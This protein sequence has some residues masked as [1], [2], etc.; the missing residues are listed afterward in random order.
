[1]VLRDHARRRCGWRRGGWKAR[2]WE[3]NPGCSLG[4]GCGPHWHWTGGTRST[5][6]FAPSGV[7]SVDRAYGATLPRSPSP[8]E[9]LDHLAESFEDLV[10]F[11]L[12]IGKLPL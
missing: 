10:A 6:G 3:A 9:I 8:M 5:R 7:H 11:H 2:L 4:P 1:M 12:L